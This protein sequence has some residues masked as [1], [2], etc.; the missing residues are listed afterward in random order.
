MKILLAKPRGYCAGVE[1]AIECLEKALELF[2]SPLYV[3][4]HIVHNTF[5]VEKFEKRGV[6]FV[7][8]LDEIPFGS[9]VVYS[10]HGVAPEVY[11]LSR[12]RN[13]RVIDATCP[14]VTKVHSEARNFARAGYTILLIGHRGHDEVVGVMGEAPQEIVLLESEQGIDA[15]EV[16]DPN[17]VAYLTQ[18]TLSVDDTQKIISALQRRF[19]NIEGPPK[20]DIC[21]ATQ[22]RQDAVRT[23]SAESDLA[24]V[25][26]SRDSS[27]SQRLVEV[28]RSNGIPAYLVDGPEEID[29]TWFNGVST[30]TVTAGASVPEELVVKT[31]EWLKLHFEASVEGRTL[32][33]ELVQFQL[34]KAV[35]PEKM[36]HHSAVGTAK[37]AS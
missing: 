32:K 4:H 19:P 29:L 21:Y 24:L 20:E 17:R 25:I 7:N 26:G 9:T 8:D 3:Y 27:N 10:A 22:N 33:Q 28:A 12:L 15:A 30:V 6:I 14:L 34:P 35:R 16:N 37:A 23:L 13:L 36:P 1:M 5:L 11:R 18:T 2:G 31:V